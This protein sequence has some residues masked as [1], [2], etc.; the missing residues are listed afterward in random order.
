MN[1]NAYQSGR[2]A[3]FQLLRLNGPK[4]FPAST[5]R[6]YRR[7]ARVVVDRYLRPGKRIVLLTPPKMGFG[8]HLYM[9]LWVHGQNR[10]GRTSVL[11]YDEKMAHWLNVLPSLSSLTIEP[12]DVKWSDKRV[13][14]WAQQ[15]GRDWTIEQMSSFISIYLKPFLSAD[16]DLDPGRVVLSVR[17]GD[18]YSNPDFR[19]MYGFNINGYVE[20]A[21]E[22][23][24]GLGRVQRVHVVSD[25]PEWCRNNLSALGT[26]PTVSY[27]EVGS[28]E[29]HF[30][31][32]C[33]AGRLVLSNST[34][35][36]WGAYVAVHRGADPRN[37]VAPWFHSRADYD[38]RAYQLDPRWTVVESIPGGWSE[39]R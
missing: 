20:K 6:L 8:N 5:L 16:V 34:F 12:G 15:F 3:Q 27:E 39:K 21:L 33:S 9:W 24:R 35:A 10:S 23:Q 25:D 32:L 26:V 14:L 22:V 18:F 37:V 30:R 17:R 4:S 36:Y 2:L 28:P 13:V 29:R 11:T 19:R 38:G 7:R 1:K 31:Q